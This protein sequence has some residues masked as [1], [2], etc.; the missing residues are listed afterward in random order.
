MVSKGH[1]N[2]RCQKGKKGLDNLSECQYT[3]PPPPPPLVTTALQPATTN[4]I[5]SPRATISLLNAFFMPPPLHQFQSFSLQDSL[6][7]SSS[8]V[9]L[10]S[11]TPRLFE[12][13]IGDP[14]TSTSPSIDS[15]AVSNATTAVFQ[16][17]KF[18]E[19]V[20]Y[21]DNGKL[22]IAPDGNGFIPTYAGGHMV[23][24]AIKP[25]Y[26]ESWGSWN[27]IRLNIRVLM[28]NQFVIKCA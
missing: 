7:S 4:I 20:E 12:L 1:G 8:S 10:T 24:K 9:P 25:F 26:I 13:R 28:W 16:I 5:P 18:K 6:H 17:P 2:G 23:I 14:N 11:S 22:I 15:A 3:P 21:D 27:E 19:V